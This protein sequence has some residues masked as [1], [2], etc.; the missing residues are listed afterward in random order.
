MDRGNL[1]NKCASCSLAGKSTLTCTCDKTLSTIDL[2]TSVLPY[3]IPSKLNAGETG[4]ITDANVPLPTYPPT[5]LPPGERI[6]VDN[7]ALACPGGHVG[8]DC[9]T[10]DSGQAAQGSMA[11]AV[12]GAVLG[13]YLFM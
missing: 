13:G 9:T 5:H 8:T 12:G 7:G 4:W 11:A 3:S 10:A 1:H 6:S 2:G